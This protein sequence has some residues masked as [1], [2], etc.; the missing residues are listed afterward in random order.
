MNVPADPSQ[1]RPPVQPASTAPELLVGEPIG[2]Y[3]SSHRQLRGISLAELSQQTRIPLRSLE[4][5]EHGSFDGLADGFV[6]GFVRTVADALGLDP[7]ETVSRLRAEPG[8]EVGRR[9]IRRLSL[10]R[11][12]LTFVT[13]AMLV[14]LFSVSRSA[15]D[16]PMTGL[17]HDA[18]PVMVRRDPVRALAEA[19][20]I[21]G[22]GRGAALAAIE[23]VRRVKATSRDADPAISLDAA[24]SF[25]PAMR[26][27][28]RPPTR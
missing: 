6:R 11:V 28:S 9:P 25:D 24:I 21:D 10:R 23:K 26:A 8:N 1:T 2:A 7:E 4:R 17:P 15:L 5:L 13:A 19:Q 22:L 3:L 16:S 18:K 14:G 27:R 20:G 12:F